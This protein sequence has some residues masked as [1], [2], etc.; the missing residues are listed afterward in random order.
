M[1][2][3]GQEQGMGTVW[4]WEWGAGV[5]EM[6]ETALLTILT[7]A[8]GN[9]LW[10][11]ERILKYCSAGAKPNQF[12]FTVFPRVADYLYIYFHLFPYSIIIYL[13]LMYL[14]V[15]YQDKLNNGMYLNTSASVIRITCNIVLQ[16]TVCT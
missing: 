2:I 14:L 10:C 1:N 4:G 7:A 8:E 9:F 6:E 12:T 11:F 3:Q 15:S 5:W 16:V 13:L